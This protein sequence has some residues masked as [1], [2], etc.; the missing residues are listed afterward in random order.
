MYSFLYSLRVNNH[1]VVKT[2]TVRYKCCY[3]YKRNTEAGGGCEKS[4]ELKSIMDTLDDIK[5]V[6]FKKLIESTEMVS[7]FND[8]NYSLFVPTDDAL[9]DYNDKINE[10]VSSSKLIL[11]IHSLNFRNSNIFFPH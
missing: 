3:G 7:T 5:T 10:M 2:F 8:G 6:E 9:N 1:G 11:F 4:G